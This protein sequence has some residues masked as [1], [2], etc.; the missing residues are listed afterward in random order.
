MHKV[1]LNVTD[2]VII[3]KAEGRE[4]LHAWYKIAM[5]AC[6]VSGLVGN[7]IGNVIAYMLFGSV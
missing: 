3:F 4:T 2:E 5:P 7:I 6:F 1:S